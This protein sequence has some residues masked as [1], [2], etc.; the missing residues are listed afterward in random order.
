MLYQ[1]PE[2][3]RITS[4]DRIRLTD[5]YKCYRD[6]SL[7]IPNRGTL[8]TGSRSGWVVSDATFAPERG[9][10]AKYEINWEAGGPNCG[11]T[12]PATEVKLDNQELYPSVTR[13]K[14]FQDADGKFLLQGPD[15]AL[16][17]ATVHGST[18]YMRQNAMDQLNGRAANPANNPSA[19][20]GVALAQML[21]NGEETF[22]LAGWRYSVVSYSFTA[23]STTLGGI[24]QVP[25]PQPSYYGYFSTAVS[26]LRLADNL[27]SV[28]PINSMW[29]LAQ[30]WLGGPMGHWNPLLYS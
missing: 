17:Q 25:T 4:S 30:T 7:T 13:N 8:G 6:M 26:W 21:Q 3:G 20:L 5:T 14:Y 10:I 16:A 27:E 11:L 18:Q 12:P 24:I 1:Q 22:Y 15:L 29:K 9:Q 2:S 28:G 19:T 23:P